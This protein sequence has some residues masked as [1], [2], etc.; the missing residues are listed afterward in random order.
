[1]MANLNQKSKPNI[2]ILGAGLVGR[3][4]AVSLAKDVDQACDITL[5]D[6]DDGHA[7]QSAGWLAAAMLSPAA[8]SADASIDIMHM[9]ER[10]LRLWPEF[11]AQ[12]STPVFFQ[13]QGSLVLAFEQDMGD[14]QQFKTRLKS[15]DYTLVN[16]QDILELE[17]GINRRFSHGVFLPN[18]GQLDN[19][20]LLLALK[21]ELVSLGVT[22]HT[23]QTIALTATGYSANHTPLPQFDWVFDCR[24]LGAKPL[25]AVPASMSGIA[26]AHCE[27]RGVRGEVIRLHAPQ[28]HLT[29]PVRLM[30]PRYP[31][32]IAPKPNGVFVVGATQLE[33]QDLRLPTVRSALEL[34]SACFSVHSGFAEAEILSMD[35]GLRPTYVNNEP[36]IVVQNRTVSV[37]GLY[38]H[39]YLLAPLMVQACKQI[40][41][42]IQDD[43]LRDLLQ[44]T[45]F[46]YARFG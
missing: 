25:N 7:T 43:S 10:A 1:M 16:A 33:S 46:S 23:Q 38:R 2:A 27:L 11:L 29:R 20:G 36:R 3:M 19:R 13:Q 14:L 9:G 39:G 31:L 45:E 18:E 21:T 4:L 42:G 12:L 37:N 17:P 6:Q 40:V 8:E 35:A 32:Y 22:W 41:Q 24:G 15:T 34:L 5:Y 26:K 28:V 30:H 44:F